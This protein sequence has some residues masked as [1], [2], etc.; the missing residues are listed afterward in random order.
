MTKTRVNEV[1]CLSQAAKVGVWKWQNESGKLKLLNL[2]RIPA[3]RLTS[4]LSMIAM[5]KW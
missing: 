2:H 1:G 3:T 5:P 4:P